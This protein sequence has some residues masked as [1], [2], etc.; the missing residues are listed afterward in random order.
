M[1]LVSIIIIA[2]ALAMDSFAVSIAGGVSLKCFKW[3]VFSFTALA[4]GFFQA[5]FFSAGYLLASLVS[6]WVQ[7]WDHWIAFA[8]LAFVGVHM[9][10]EQGRDDGDKLID[11]NRKRVV[12][13]LAVATSI[14]AL[15]VGVSFSILDFNLPLMLFVIALVSALLSGVGVLM[16][17]KLNKAERFPAHLIGGISLCAIGVKVL[18]EHLAQ[19]I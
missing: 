6:L 1:N 12:L 13:A 15:A 16:G 4:M 17:C 18:I 3:R 8:I 11:L 7:K 5:A 2:L 10:L 14:D 19:H 9:I